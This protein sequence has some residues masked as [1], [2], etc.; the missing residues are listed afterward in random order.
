MSRDSV[1]DSGFFSALFGIRTGKDNMTN[2]WSCW[3]Q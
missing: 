2:V 3:M 1:K